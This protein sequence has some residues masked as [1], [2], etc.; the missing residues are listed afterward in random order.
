MAFQTKEVLPNLI[1]LKILVWG[2]I[3]KHTCVWCL[4][5]RWGH[6]VSCFITLHLIPFRQ[7]LSLKLEL[8]WQSVSPNSFPSPSIPICK[9]TDLYV[10]MLR[11]LDGCWEFELRSS[12]L[13]TNCS[14]PQSHLPS[15]I[16]ETFSAAYLMEDA[17]QLWTTTIGYGPIWHFFKVLYSGSH[18]TSE[19]N[20]PLLRVTF[21]KRS[22][23][24]DITF[25]R[26]A[27]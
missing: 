11:F 21:G 20:H 12:C 8:G 15:L 1:S 9:I 17:C 6:Y 27:W 25:A 24:L 13:F 2:K 23:N 19:T 14:Y 26:R 22:F 7:V 4:R 3:H 18:M 5:T 10:A 16:W